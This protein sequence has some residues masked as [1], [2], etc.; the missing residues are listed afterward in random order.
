[1]FVF[2][3]VL[4]AA[5]C[6]ALDILFVTGRKKV[7]LAVRAVIRDLLTVSLLSLAFQR[8]VL[9]YAHF[10]DSSAYD[11]WD[12]FKFFLWALGVGLAVVFMKALVRR[13]LV[14]EPSQKPRR[15]KLAMALRI[16]AVVLFFLGMAAY[17][18]TVW[19]K[20]AFGNVTGDQ[21][22]INL[23]SPTE[24]T[25]ASVYLDG[26]EGPVFKTFLCTAL[27]GILI[28]S[29]VE[30]R[31]I[32]KKKRVRVL[33]EAVKRGVCLA[34]GASMLVGGVV[35][36]YNEYRLD[37][38]IN[39]Y[40]LKSTLIDDNFADPATVKITWPEQKR[41]L[42]H[43]YL[44][45]M[46]FSFTSK[47]K[48]GFTDEDFIPNL[49]KVA[50]EGIV[51]SDTD[52][53]YGGPLPGTGTQ[54]SLAS[55]VNQLT[56]LPMKA[57]GK[58]NSYGKNG[59][60]LPGAYTLGEMLEAQGY[61]QTVMIGASATF[62]GLNYLFE[63]HGNWKIM[64]YN[65]AKNTGLIPQDYKVNWG[66]EDDK[67]FE[68]AKEEITRLYNTGKPFNF[69]M[70]TADTHRPDGYVTPG[71]ET[72]YQSPYA[73]A[74]FNNDKDVTAFLDWLK[75]QPFYENTTVVIIGD[76]LSMETRFFNDYDLPDDYPR[77]Q[78][79]VILNPAPGLENPGYEVTHNRLWANWDML[80]TIV[81]ALG[82]KIEGERLGVGTNLFSGEKTIYEQYGV[83]K[84]D[85]EFEKASPLYTEKILNA[86]N[87]LNVLKEN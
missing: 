31:Y 59:Q 38:L 46:E 2:L 44:E 62:G 28:F 21:L 36:G 77:R 22:L 76:H 10:L 47:E 34:L 86:D 20:E 78:Y 5:I 53:D 73:N 4:A 64:D 40:V 79:N 1:M 58:A 49:M 45:S 42:I 66:Y 17:T 55:M 61:E 9:E 35:Y 16:V 82:A 85:R 37:Q 87:L 84:V 68:Y 63:T 71:K 29:R 11:A 33:P 18:G 51:F 19:G 3:A 52:S 32:G 54:W 67:L 30:L 8:Y 43:I 12:F 50:D 83:K 72:P 41:N 14:F 13:V 75:E 80:P 27:F 15:P 24:G 60:F 48:G 39:A 70:E 57:P 6:A 81:A 69:T 65:Y 23:T 25:E 7:S 56:G 74:L 26:F